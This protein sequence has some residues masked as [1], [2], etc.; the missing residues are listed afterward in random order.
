MLCARFPENHPAVRDWVILILLM[1]EILRRLQLV[2]V[3]VGGGGG[4]LLF[5][6]CWLL[7]VRRCRSSSINRIDK[8]SIMHA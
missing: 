2:V 6:R 5:I 4:W 1:H 7:V 3:V 8:R